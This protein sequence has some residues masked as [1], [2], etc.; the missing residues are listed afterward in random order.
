[1]VKLLIVAALAVLACRVLTGR[2]PWELFAISERSGAEAQ[3][4]AL[5]GVDRSASRSAIVEAHRRLLA[6]VHPDRGGSTEQVHA[7]N[8]ARDLLLAR[9]DRLS[10]E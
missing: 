6:Q 1:M 10:S 5:L 2:W 9:L 8:A 4:R 3:A 7:A